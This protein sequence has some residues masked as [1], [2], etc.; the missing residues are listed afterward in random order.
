MVHR[1]FFIN[2]SFVFLI[3][4]VLLAI[5][6]YDRAD[7]ALENILVV[8][9]AVILGYSYR[10][11]PLSRVSYGLIFSFLLLHEIGSHYTY[12]KV[13]YEAFAKEYLNVSINQ[14]F[15]WERNNFDRVVHFLYG[16]FLAYPIREFYYRVANAK[17]FWGYFFPLELT[18]ASSMIFELFEWL[19]AETVGGDL[20]VAYLGTQGDIWDAHKDMALA[21]L[22][23]A[24]AMVITLLVNLRLQRNF[25]REW[26]DSLSIKYH[27]PLGEDK[28]EKMLGEKQNNSDSGES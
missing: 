16:L 17:G 21:S 13:P 11:F 4:F 18:M 20:G 26:Q 1:R 9:F 2:L 19:A 14:I 28:L 15:G 23:A 12:A 5:D 24:I 3:V 25:E 10:K 8:V 27:E 22:G 6:P 7:W